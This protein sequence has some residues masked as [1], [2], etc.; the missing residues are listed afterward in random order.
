MI[1]ELQNQDPLDPLKNDELLSQI[2]QIRE[3]GATDRLTQTLESVL[4]G[5]NIASATNLIG[6][7]VNA[8]SDENER[9]D[10]IVQRVSIADG[11][12]KLNL[13][14]DTQVRPSGEP[15]NVEAGTYRYR[16]VWQGT[17]GQ[18]LGLELDEIKTTG[19]V[20]TDRAIRISNLPISSG[21]KQV[22]RTDAEGDD[23]SFRLVATLTDGEKPSFVDT[24][25]DDERS[26]LHLT[27]PFLRVP[28]KRTFEISLNNVS[29][30][31]PL[32]PDA[33]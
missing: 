15:G 12:P 1:T 7:Y 24:L 19:E 18:L 17:N 10:G 32:I 29:E 22:Y 8:I 20:D 26:L 11:V 5:Q 16:V 27:Q 33:A 4:L 9:V 2:S 13:E 23:S 21:P 6:N 31:R 25:S 3:V 14:N 30:I 28:A